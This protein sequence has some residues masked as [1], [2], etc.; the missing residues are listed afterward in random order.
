MS[1]GCF[2]CVGLSVVCLVGFVYAGKAHCVCLALDAVPDGPQR[3][4]KVAVVGMQKC[5][6]VPAA[7][8]Y[9]FSIRGDPRL[10]TRVLT[11]SRSTGVHSRDLSTFVCDAVEFFAYRGHSLAHPVQS[12]F[13]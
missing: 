10:G 1:T 11:E 7:H 8:N 3:A 9:E 12:T 5:I 13:F 4:V 6:Q 2:F